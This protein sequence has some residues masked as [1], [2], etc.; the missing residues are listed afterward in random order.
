MG[1]GAGRCGWHPVSDGAFQVKIEITDRDFSDGL[2][3]VLTEVP[4]N[5]L[6]RI[7]G[8]IIEAISDRP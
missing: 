1:V 6:E 2:K 5:D 7:I 3:I 8:N 4:L